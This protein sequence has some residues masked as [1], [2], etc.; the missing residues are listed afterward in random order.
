[1]T[2]QKS[3]I[4]Q[5]ENPSKLHQLKIDWKFRNRNCLGSI[6]LPPHLLMIRVARWF[7]FISKI[8]IWVNFGGPWNW[9]WWHILWPFGVFCGH[10]L[11]FMAV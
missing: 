9:K 8:P 6:L 4:F 1:M 7:I 5:L 10:L 11:Y 2:Q 3:M